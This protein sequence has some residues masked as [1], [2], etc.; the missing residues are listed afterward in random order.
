MNAK[1]SDCELA[2]KVARSPFLN[3]LIIGM[4]IISLGKKKKT[5]K[6][7]LLLKRSD[8]FFS[9]S[10]NNAADFRVRRGHVHVC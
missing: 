6:I 9:E 2:E 3:P 4:T 10:D 5:L 7:F 8:R 1:Q